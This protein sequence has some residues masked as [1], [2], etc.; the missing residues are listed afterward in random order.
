MS[1]QPRPQPRVLP[2]RPNLRHLKLE[3]KR[4]LA[5]GEF[6]TLHDSQLAIAREHGHSSWAA[7]KRLIESQPHSASHALDQVRWLVTRFAGADGPGWVAPDPG[8]LREHFDDHFLTAIPAEQLVST[9]T[10]QAGVLGQELTVTVETPQHAQAQ[11]GGLQI[12]AATEPEA[13]HRLAMLRVFPIG[14]RVT[15]P[16]VAAPSSRELGGVPAVAHAA[17]DRALA[18]LGLPGL[19]LAGHGSGDRDGAGWVLARG[20]ADL[21]RGQPMRPDHQVPAYSITKLVTATTVLRLAGDGWL[22]LDDPANEHLRTVRLA[23]GAVTVRDLLRHTG[24]VDSPAELFGPAVPDLRAL[25]GPVI[26]CHGE[27]GVFAYSNAGYAMLGQ[28]IADVCGAPHP[29]VTARLV[30]DPLGMNQSFFPARWP[31]PGQNAVTGHR[32]EPD[33]VFRAEADEICTLPAAGGLWST[34]T[35]LVRFGRAWHKLLPVG[36]A[37]EALRPQA[38]RADTGVQ[39]GF[40]W[41]INSGRGVAGHAGGGQGGA[42]SLIVT[43]GGRV[44]VALTNRLIPVEPVNAKVLR[45]MG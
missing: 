21:D 2:S 15:D 18:E 42:S 28:L 26:G 31:E 9:I 16:R 12:E 8:E 11:I 38:T 44:H 34:A 41:H 30:L 13:P 32:L 23:D 37:R 3:A 1:D 45:A 36:L 19:V 29:E 4:R 22:G 17:A 10:G 5:A 43:D 7:L 27:R 40:G 20:W 24:G 14:G 39:V 6:T 33:G 35:D 25:T